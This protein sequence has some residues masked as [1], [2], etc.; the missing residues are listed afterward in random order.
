MT[1]DAGSQHNR[2]CGADCLRRSFPHFAADTPALTFTSPKAA[3]KHMEDVLRA[4]DVEIAGA[5][6]PVPD[7]FDR[8]PMWSE[9]VA[10]LCSRSHALAGRKAVDLQELSV[11]PFILFDPRF[12]LHDI[13]VDAC[14]R[15]G[16][17]QRVVA[18]SSQITFML[19]LA[20]DGLGVT[21]IPK[22]IAEAYGQEGVAMIEFTDNP[23]SWDMTLAWRRGA[24]L[25]QAATAWLALAADMGAVSRR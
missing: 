3:A 17:S 23:I 18:E 16:F 2:R 1:G 22:L 12:A 5:L 19:K 4:G 24:F 20:A 8:L 21:F 10:A 15:G 11:E 13:I 6:Q 7:E 25:S 9:P 14:A